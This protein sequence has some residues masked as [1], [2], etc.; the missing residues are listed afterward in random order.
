[1]VGIGGGVGRPLVAGLRL[2]EEQPDLVGQARLVVLQRQQ[3]VGTLGADRRGDAALA[4]HGVDGDQGAGQLQPL[5]Q[6]RYGDDF[7]AF[8]GGGLLPQH[9][10]LAA[11]PG[12]D[13]MQRVGVHAMGTARG[14]AVDRHDLGRAVGQAGDPGGEAG[15]EGRGIECVEHVAQRV[16]RRHAAGERQEARQNCLIQC[17]AP[18]KP[19]NSGRK[20][21][22]R[23]LPP[24][25]PLRYRHDPNPRARAIW[26]PCRR[27][28]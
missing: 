8:D 7:I 11:G 17:E 19:R 9:Q 18:Y 25:A 20:G 27:P 13:D 21:A 12:R 15:R 2:V 23:T 5:Q 28:G 3:V 26:T 6:Q 16:M 22:A 24:K 14:L 1:M 4:A 10:S